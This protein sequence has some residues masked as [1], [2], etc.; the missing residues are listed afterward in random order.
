MSEDKWAEWEDRVAAEHDLL[1][2]RGDCD[3]CDRTN[4]SITCLPDPFLAEI[5][6][7]YDNVSSNWCEECLERRR[8]AGRED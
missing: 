2:G 7:D 8:A 4:V 5:C 1:E 3:H 6:P